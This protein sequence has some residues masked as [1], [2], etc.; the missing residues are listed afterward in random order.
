MAKAKEEV[1]TGELVPSGPQA[2]GE[3]IPDFIPVGQ[4]T[5]AEGI[6]REDIQMPRIAIAQGTSKQMLE[7]NQLFIDGLRLGQMF[8]TLTSDIYGK[9][10]IEVIIVRR[11]PPRWAEF[12]EDRNMIDPDVKPGDPRTEWR[13]NEK[14]E[15]LPPIATQFYDFIVYVPTTGETVALSMSKT[16]IKAAK[17]LNGLIKMR[18]PPVPIYARRFLISTAME[19]NDKGTY[20]VFVVATAGTQGVPNSDLVKDRDTF[21]LVKGIHEALQDAYIDIQREPDDSFD[22]ATMEAQTAQ[23]STSA[24]GM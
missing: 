18:I 24:P 19:T 10:P 12:D 8:N 20:G 14:G 3:A 5:G 2:I 11:D 17:K 1:K 23:A 7:G 21:N 9:G 15:R 22:T 4:A 6:G 13:T 16:N